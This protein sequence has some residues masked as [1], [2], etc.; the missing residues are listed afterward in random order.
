MTEEKFEERKGEHH[1]KTV[2]I[3]VNGR[4]EKVEK[5]KISY[6]KVVEFAYPKPDYEQFTYK[7]TYFRKDDKREGVLTKGESVEVSEE[8]SFTVNR[9]FR[10]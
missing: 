8:M 5:G 3:F 9:S 1:H 7:V 4:P 2:T 10:S 6:D